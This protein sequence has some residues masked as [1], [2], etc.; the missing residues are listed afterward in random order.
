[1]RNYHTKLDFL[2]EVIKSRDIEWSVERSYIIWTHDHRNEQYHGGKKGVPEINTLK[3][4]RT[5]ALWIFSILFDVSNVETVLEQAILAQTHQALP[6][7]DRDF[8]IAINR[9]YGIIT[10][11]EQDYYASELLFAV[12]PDAYLD[13]GGKLIDDSIEYTEG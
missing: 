6:S 12:D 10:V 5:A 7:R 3:I 13:L 2:E 11:G 1:M 9:E 8:D 4:A